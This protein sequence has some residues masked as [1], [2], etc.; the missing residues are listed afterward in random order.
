MKTLTIE[1]MENVTA[2]NLKRSL[3]CASQVAGGM[4]ALV[5]IAA[6]GSFALGPIGWFAFGL[7]ALS[8]VASAI[9]DPYAC[10]T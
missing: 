4:S 5:T 9:A 3:T 2:G 10:D 7:G 1:Q 6:I 8:F